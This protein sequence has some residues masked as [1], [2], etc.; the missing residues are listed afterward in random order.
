M[1]FK[2]IQIYNM[3]GYLETHAC[4]KTKKL[5]LRGLRK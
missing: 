4:G 1:R 3:C 2:N 5:S